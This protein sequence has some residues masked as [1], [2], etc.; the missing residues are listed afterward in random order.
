[1]KRLAVI[2]RSH[3]IMPEAEVSSHP[4]GGA[5]IGLRLEVGAVCCLRDPVDVTLRVTATARVPVP[6]GA[7][8]SIAC[9]IQLTSR[10]VFE[11]TITRLPASAPPGMYGTSSASNAFHFEPPST[12]CRYVISHG[13]SHGISH[14]IRQVR[15]HASTCCRAMGG[16]RRHRSQHCVEM[17]QRSCAGWQEG[18][19]SESE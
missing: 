1:M 8:G 14:V 11:K 13:I 2:W 3:Q 7:G 9:A 17:R 15:T 16:G 18:G 6:V 5:G 19:L 4:A 12:T 10:F